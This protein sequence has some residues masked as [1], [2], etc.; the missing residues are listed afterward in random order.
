MSKRQPKKKGSVGRILRQG[1]FA[2]GYHSSR[3]FHE[4][5]IKF[6][7]SLIFIIIL[8]YMPHSSLYLSLL[9]SRKT[10]MLGQPTLVLALFV[11]QAS[12]RLHVIYFFKVFHHRHITSNRPSI[13]IYPRGIVLCDP[14]ATDQPQCRV[15]LTI[16]PPLDTWLPPSTHLTT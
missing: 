8:S 3:A 14:V 15:G 9:K 10:I 4:R 13:T 7:F 5:F 16:L 11:A 6:S 2:N 1:E 12:L